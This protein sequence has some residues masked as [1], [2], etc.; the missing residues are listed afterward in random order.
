MPRSKSSSAAIA[1]VARQIEKLKNA[2]LIG[3]KDDSKSSKKDDSKSSKKDE[4]IESKSSKKVDNKTDDNKSDDNKTDN[5]KEKRPKTEYQIFVSN[6]LT[7]L[8]EKY[9]N[10]GI[11]CP[12]YRDLMKIITTEWHDIKDNNTNKVKKDKETKRN[13]SEYNLFIKSI[14]PLLKK[15]HENDINKL[16]QKDY[17]KLAAEKWREHKESKNLIN[18]VKE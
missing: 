10:D 14:I 18:K 11:A 13:P 8:R 6:K 9:K 1:T 7:E 2:N 12:G 5:N 15:E 4:K 16:A 17:M 3:N